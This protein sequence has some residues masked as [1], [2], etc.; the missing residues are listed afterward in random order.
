MCALLVSVTCPLAYA[1]DPGQ[2]V[3]PYVQ[4]SYLH[5]D[6]VL[7]LSGP[8]AAVSALGAPK[9]SDSVQSRTVGLKLDRDLSRQH[10]TL[11]ASVT[12]NT[13]DY[14]SQFDNDARDLKTNWS[15]VLGE[16][17][18]GDIGYVYS[19]S[20]TPFQNFRILGLN[21]R[22]MQTQYATLAWQLHP[23]WTVRSQ[24]SHFSLGYDLPTQ[25]ANN[26]SQNLAELGL[27][28]NPRSGSVV[29]V[30]VRKTEGRYPNDV[31][32]GSDLINNSYTQEDYKLKVLWLYSAKTKLQFLG[33]L[34]QR[35]RRSPTGGNGY[36]GFN[37][38]LIG[39]WAATGKTGFVVNLWREIGGISDVDANFALT[40][41]ASVAATYLPTAKLRVEGLFDVERRNYNGASIIAGVTPSSRR[42]N[43]EK[44]SLSLTYSPT[45][46]LSMMLAVYRE[47]SQSNIANL[48]YV[49]N[50]VSLTS[51]YEF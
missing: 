26:F 8:A 21:I 44:A 10:V 23:D 13:Y 15:W 42:D 35:D 18:S 27:D 6:N 9:L 39:D 47:N 34:T 40:T 49:S 3:V 11:D 16:R 45:T 24:V 37:A 19:R 30:Q 20:L 50:G 33:G 22:T 28:Y 48:G 41:G 36:R 5:D 12:K 4:Y 46:S 43:Y 51:R 17:F 7:R 31:L 25:Q 14:F 1:A 32:V 29:G 2:V 38:R